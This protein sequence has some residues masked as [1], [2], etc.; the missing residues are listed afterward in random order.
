MHSSPSDPSGEVRTVHQHLQ[1]EIGENC[2]STGLKVMREFLG[3]L[4]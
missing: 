4:N 2:D 3:S 1:W